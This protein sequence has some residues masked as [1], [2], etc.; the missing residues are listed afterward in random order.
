MSYNLDNDDYK[1]LMAIETV[2]DVSDHFRGVNTL[3]MLCMIATQA[4]FILNYY[5]KTLIKFN[6]LK[7]ILFWI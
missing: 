7:K 2:T 6:H 4:C 1:N 5:Y 3:T